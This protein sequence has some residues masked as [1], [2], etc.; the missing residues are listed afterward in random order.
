M[1]N[2]IFCK[3]AKGEIPAVKIWEDDRFLATL[4]IYPNTLGMVLVMPKV[5]YDSY[6]F[7]MPEDVYSEFFLAAKKV[8]KILETG[9][10]VKR[11]ALVM[12]GM[13]VNH[14]HLKLYPLYGLEEKFKETWAKDKVFFKNYQGYISTQLGPQADIAELKKLAEVIR[15]KNGLTQ[16]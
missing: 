9:L 15:K 3:I 5:H 10:D 16:S 11:V 1:D 7:D 8:S 4:D 14:A 2:C 13:G 12:E 6:V